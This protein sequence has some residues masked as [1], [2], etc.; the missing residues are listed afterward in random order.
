MTM[1][2]LMPTDEHGSPGWSQ[3]RCAALLLLLSLAFCAG[4]ELSA[5]HLFPKF[6]RVR[7]RISAEQKAAIAF[8]TCAASPAV[9][10][11]GNSLFERGV[12]IP[13]LQQELA[14]Y[15]VKRFVVSD[16]SY[17]DWYYGLRRLFKEGA[18]PQTV[19]IGL[20]ANQLIAQ[21]IEGELS[22]NL[23]VRTMDVFNVG[24][25]LHLNNTDVSILYFANI[26][27]FYGNRTQFRKWLLAKTVPGIDLLASAIRPAAHALPGNTIVAMEAFARL[28]AMNKLCQENGARLILVV[29]P[30]PDR[31]SESI[32]GTVEES[33]RKAGVLVLVPVRPGAMPL[34]KFSDG[35]HLNESGAVQ[36][37]T[38]LSAELKHDIP[39]A[40]AQNTSR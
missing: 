20:S 12:Y 18:R 37:T 29:P 40:L 38:L 33:G 31:D 14:G 17:L 1:P 9:L 27:A 36:F 6:S 30:T 4:A 21:R 28:Q 16:T 7:S 10:L 39:D 11:V 25:D 23:L 19:I 13:L 35:F 32:V 8:R 34:E 5:D 22:A 2:E 24:H 15:R 26:S 3:G